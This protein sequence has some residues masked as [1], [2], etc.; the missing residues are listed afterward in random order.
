MG[1]DYNP[2]RSR[3]CFS[4][5]DAKSFKLS[6]SKIEDF[7]NCPRCFYLDRRCGTGRPPSYP[8]TLNNAVDTLLK[9]EFDQY[10]AEVKPHPICLA[11]KIDAIPFSHPE[12]DNWRMNLKGI[13]YLHETTNFII[14]G[15]VDDIWVKPDGELIVVDYKA[16]STT[17]EI[18][19]EEEY[20]QSYKRQMEIYQWLLR[21]IGFRVS[22]MGYFVYCNGDA[23]KD[24]F[25]GKLE[26]KISVLPYEGDDSWI[27]SILFN[28]HKCLKSDKFPDSNVSCDF[29]N[30]R[31]AVRKHL[32]DQE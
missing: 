12:L 30:Y 16:T 23:G 17:K 1:S 9:K 20:R 8:F 29:C 13:Q 5:S 3:N 11:H 31:E 2:Q 14:T 28:I 24:D 15:A 7:L 26:F 25:I 4:S 32:K 6:R 21:K 10:R 27:E 18:T 19:L 22:N